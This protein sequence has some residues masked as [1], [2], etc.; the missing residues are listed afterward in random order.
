MQTMQSHGQWEHDPVRPTTSLWRRRLRRRH[1][2]RPIP[3]PGSRQSRHA[4][5]QCRQRLAA[6]DAHRDDASLQVA[7]GH[8][9]CDPKSEDRSGRSYRVTQRDRTAV[10]VD[11]RRVEL[12]IAD[13]S[14]RLGCES[15]IELDRVDVA[16]PSACS[17]ALIDRATQEVAR[18]GG[19]YRDWSA[20]GTHR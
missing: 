8:V 10:R 1:W 11:L 14:H 5:K 20:H 19:R 3:A 17:P 18:H 4:L 16:G 12:C 6:T 9:L 2:L 13:D 15:F 7:T